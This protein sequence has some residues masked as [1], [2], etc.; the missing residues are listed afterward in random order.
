MP[1]RTT[2][3]IQLTRKT[4]K[5]VYV[6]VQNEDG[7]TTNTLEIQPNQIQ[8][9]H[10]AP[11]EVLSVYVDDAPHQELTEEGDRPRRDEQ[12]EQSEQQQK[13]QAELA[14]QRRTET[15]SKK[16]SNKENK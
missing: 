13:E 4:N 6:D 2:L 12:V 7:D 1:V 16:Q 11:G 14:E 8:Q 3:S 5:N 10:I 9:V 15:K